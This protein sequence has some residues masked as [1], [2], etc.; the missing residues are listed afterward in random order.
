MTD[1][2]SELDRDGKDPAP[3]GST[4]RAVLRGALVAGALPLLAACG[5]GDSTDASSTSGGVGNGG[6]NGADPTS[7]DPPGGGN[8]GAGTAV[9]PIAQTTDVPE[10]GGIILDDPGVVIT[11]PDPNDFKGFSNICTHMHCPVD[12]VS[13]GTINCV[14]HGSQFSI[15]DGS[16]VAGPAPTPLPAMQLKVQGKNISLA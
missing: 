2:W 15:T 16:V 8:G 10:G 1:V 12:N 7:A 11:Q 9:Q 5:G 14:C 6:G 4:R 3:A 13:D